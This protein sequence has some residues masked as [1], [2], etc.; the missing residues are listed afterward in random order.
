MNSLVGNVDSRLSGK[1]VKHKIDPKVRIRDN[2][3]SKSFSW[4]GNYFFQV[5]IL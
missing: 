2:H 3:I 4:G 1:K 5:G